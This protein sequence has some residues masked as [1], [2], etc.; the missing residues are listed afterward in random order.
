[1][2]MRT[3]LS[4]GK[5]RM[6]EEMIGLAKPKF[7]FSAKEDGTEED[8]LGEPLQSLNNNIGFSGGMVKPTDGQEYKTKNQDGG[9]QKGSP[10]KSSTTSG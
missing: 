4:P 1:V 3:S 8:V 2:E 6:G 10:F 9:N 7:M 5:K